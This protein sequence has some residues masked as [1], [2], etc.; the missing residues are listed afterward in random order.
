MK[1]SELFKILRSD[2]RMAIS[3]KGSHV[4]MRHPTKKGILIVPNHGS[5]EM[6]K[7]LEKDILKKAGLR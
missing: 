5:K 7:G 6:A 4:K 3:Q 2:D 1:C